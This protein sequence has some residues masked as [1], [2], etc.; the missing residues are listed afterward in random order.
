V[1]LAALRRLVGPRHADSPSRTLEDLDYD[2]KNDRNAV[3]EKKIS[4]A[5]FPAAPLPLR[6]CQTRSALHF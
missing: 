2:V 6:L 4:A 3:T 1:I 5:G